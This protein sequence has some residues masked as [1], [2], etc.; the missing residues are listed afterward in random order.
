MSGAG[1][2]PNR[3]TPE[4][5]LL[6]KEVARI[7]D[8]EAARQGRDERCGT[9]AFR[10]GDHLANGSPETLMS[11]VKSAA[12]RTPFWCHERDRPCGGWQL[13]RVDAGKEVEVPWDHVDGAEMPE[14]DRL[15]TEGG[16]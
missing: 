5:W 10:A 6:G 14:I 16:R 13:M 12:E 4:G 7:C 3:V 8:I 2:R 11:A 9:C 15:S 1:A